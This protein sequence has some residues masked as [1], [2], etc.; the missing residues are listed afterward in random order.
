MRL[1]PGSPESSSQVNPGSSA[2]NSKRCACE[3][4]RAHTC[5]IG[6]RRQTTIV[7]G[8]TSKSV[9]R[10]QVEKALRLSHTCSSD[11]QGGRV[12][13]RAGR[14]NRDDA[15]ASVTAARDPGPGNGHSI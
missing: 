12:R 15:L 13:E 14:E 9:R 4:L 8:K 3:T 11:S 2:D 6:H 5:G 7:P 1:P 10:L